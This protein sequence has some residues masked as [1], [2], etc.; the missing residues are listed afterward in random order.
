VTAEDI[1]DIRCWLQS[2]RGSNDVLNKQGRLSGSELAVNHVIALF[3]EV[4]RLRAELRKAG[5]TICSE[6]CGTTGHSPVCRE[7]SEAID[8]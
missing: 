5:K 8:A 7:V 2:E 4:D 3:G 6:F 1:E